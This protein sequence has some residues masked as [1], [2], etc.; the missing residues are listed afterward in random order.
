MTIRIALVLSLAARIAWAQ[1]E[2]PPDPATPPSHT[3]APAAR[4]ESAAPTTTSKQRRRVR[5][6]PLV[7]GAAAGLGLAIAL[8]HPKTGFVSNDSDTG[9]TVLASLS[10]FALGILVDVT[11]AGP[12]HGRLRATGGSSS[13][14][15]WEY[16]VAYR[17]P[18]ARHISVEGLV[19]IASDSWEETELQ[20]RCGLFGCFTLNY[21]VDARYELLGSIMARVAFEPW[22]ELRFVPT[23]AVGG[24][25]SRIHVDWLHDSP[26]TRTGALF[27]ATLGVEPGGFTAELGL[28]FGVMDTVAPHET[29]G[30]FRLGY[31]WGEP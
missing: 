27:D 19:L 4:P 17:T 1:V 2:P 25:P 29:A 3:S 5:I 28:R 15:R 18:I 22:P 23:L 13:T 30:Y 12:H 21:L 31:T 10:V 24:G 9:M 11:D 16:A 7:G 6:A 26:E 20:R 14:H 8:I